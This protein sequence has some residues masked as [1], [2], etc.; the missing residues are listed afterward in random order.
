MHAAQRARR[1]AARGS[2]GAGHRYAGIEFR[3]VVL[4]ITIS[5]YVLLRE[6]MS[7]GHVEYKGEVTL[8]YVVGPQWDPLYSYSYT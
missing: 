4:L 3:D 2:R 8:V 7:K 1:Q 6:G 5:V